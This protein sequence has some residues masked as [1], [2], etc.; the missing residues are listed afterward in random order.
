MSYQSD[1][2]STID[3]QSNGATTLNISYLLELI[4]KTKK[5]LAYKELESQ[6]I[7]K[8][9]QKNDPKFLIG[10]N[11]PTI[12][13]KSKIN[14]I[15]QLPLSKRKTM[16]M[17]NY[18][19]R[20]SQ[21]NNDS[22]SLSQSS[23]TKLS[24]SQSR[25]SS[26]RTFDSYMPQY[27]VNYMIKIEMTEKECN[28]IAIV[29]QQ[30][31]QKVK[32]QLTQLSAN[33]KEIQLTNKEIQNTINDFQNFV[34][35]RGIDKLT[36]KIPLEQFIK[37]TDK[38]IK[39]G[40]TLIETMRLKTSTLRQNCC[41]QKSA[42]AIKSELS[43]ILR[44]V[45]FDQLQIEKRSFMQIIEEKNAH[46][47]GMKK[48]AGNVSQ[49]L[50]AKRK[51]L[52]I[53]LNK[54]YILTKRIEKIYEDCKRFEIEGINAENEINIWVKKINSLQNLIDTYRAPMAFDYMNKKI[55][56]Q[57][58]Q[59]ERKSFER[60]RN[61]AIIKLENVKTQLRK[62]KELEIARRLKEASIEKKFKNMLLE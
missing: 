32:K 44:P 56:L 6:M 21:I 51:S 3:Q 15:D 20:R 59:K 52:N 7:E 31:E 50:T 22:S 11:P 35:I 25:T 27:C 29:Q 14:F 5:D 61:I 37:F 46:F 58:I 1:Q 4:E 45:D 13:R 36:Q 17:D 49:S 48:V 30:Y 8:Y 10:L 39:N 43:G 12:K 23:F 26:L 62:K 54:L 41:Q 55:K 2:I 18:S 19:I 42:L 60:K 57:A 38:M 40:N 9:L 33:V 24:F 34:L 28:A 47:I 53:S 16:S